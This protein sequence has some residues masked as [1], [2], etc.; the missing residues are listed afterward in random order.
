MATKPSKLP[1]WA[2]TGG[3][4]LEPSA[5]E[6][7]AGW[8][9][10]TRAPARWMNW[11]LNNIYT[12]VQYVSDGVFVADASSGDEG[13]DATGD[14]VAAGVKGTGGA[15]NGPGVTG[16]GTGSGDGVV[17][18]SAGT[19]DGVVGTGGTSNGSGVRGVGGSS[20][21]DGVHGTGAGL[22]SGLRGYGGSTSGPGCYGTGGS[23]NGIGVKGA[24][25][26]TGDGVS[27]TGGATGAGVVGTGG[28]TSGAGVEGTGGPNSAGVSGTG[29][30]TNGNGVEGQGTGTGAGVVGTGAN[31]PGVHAIGDTTSPLAPSLIVGAQDSVPSSVVTEGGLS[32]IK[33]TLRMAD[34]SAY[35]KVPVLRGSQTAADEITA[36]T[37]DFTTQVTLPANMLKVGDVVKV[38][39]TVGSKTGTGSGTA[40]ALSVKFG[41][42]TLGSDSRSGVVSGDT[43][44]FDCTLAVWTVGAPGTGTIRRVI[45]FDPAS[46]T[47]I[48]SATAAGPGYT[49]PDTTASNVIKVTATAPTG[50]TLELLEFHVEA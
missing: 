14:G 22:A 42:L 25:T 40:T 21:G 46:G 28:S 26:G 5:G 20:D 9:V 37:A 8:A 27:G 6:K 32:V 16:V 45:F 47:T 48:A 39:V 17:G 38:R 7:A 12:W 1:E 15:T 18:S 31:G 44:H 3:T 2:T 30:A 19:G 36:T 33:T 13:I 35:R 4:T 34:G 29:G 50:D 43:W 24:G 11:I 49:T 10:G 41:S 23:P